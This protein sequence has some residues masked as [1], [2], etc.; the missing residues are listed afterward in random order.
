VFCC[1][2]KMSG[3]VEATPLNVLA[4][5]ASR[6]IGY[7]TTLYL[8]SA[9]N[10]V[11]FLLRRTTVFDG[12]VRVQEYVKSGLAK[13]VS[14]DGT[15]KE[16]VR[17]AWD[18]AAE[19]GPVDY[20][21]SSVGGSGSFSLTKGIV[22]DNPR[23]CS[24][25][26]Y[27]LL[28]NY[29]PTDVNSFEHTKLILVTSHGFTPKSRKALPCALRTL[30][31]LILATPRLDKRTME[32]FMA[33]CSPNSESY[34]CNEQEVEVQKKNGFLFDG[35]E[36]GLENG[37]WLDGM[38]IRP[39]MLTNGKS[40]CESGGYGAIRT[41][42]EDLPNAWSISRADVGWFIANKAMKEWDDW[43]GKAVSLAY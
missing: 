33:Y 27:A 34:A 4:I 43:R 1:S 6:N 12:D 17:R 3:K 40:K 41:G 14:G 25:A 2:Q 21:I 24:E 38:I 28:S 26:L 10:R 20:I 36:N 35:W 29:S 42:P 15:S 39:A 16:D 37:R 7:H 23:L 32:H 19:N 9:G 8:L 5:G 18:T 22:L 31:D 11:T 30:Y 13:L